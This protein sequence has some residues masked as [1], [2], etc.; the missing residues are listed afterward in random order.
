LGT[1]AASIAC[2][3]YNASL[4]PLSSNEDGNLRKIKEKKR[5]EKG[6]NANFS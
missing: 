6:I 2:L 1:N 3:A 4:Q 5:K